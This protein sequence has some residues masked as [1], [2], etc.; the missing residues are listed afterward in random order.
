MVC[1]GKDLYAA[2]K[3]CPTRFSIEPALAR[4]TLATLF[5][6]QIFSEAWTQGFRRRDAA[7]DVA[8]GRQAVGESAARRRSGHAFGVGRNRRASCYRVKIK[9]PDGTATF[10]IDRES[11]VLRRIVLPTDALRQELGR[12]K[13][14]RQS[15]A[16]GR[17][18]GRRSMA[19]STPRRLLR[20]RLAAPRW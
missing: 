6:D 10:W 7:S 14:Y 3:T 19:G 4:I 20:D 12:E 13:P 15:L 11:L 17:S 5:Q 2:I 1:D 16:G 18:H 9:R 8:L